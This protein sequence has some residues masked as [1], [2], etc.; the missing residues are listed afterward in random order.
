MAAKPGLPKPP[1]TGDDDNAPMSEPELDRHRK[2]APPRALTQYKG[3]MIV[4]NQGMLGYLMLPAKFELVD[5]KETS[6]YRLYEYGVT[7][8]EKMKIGHWIF[9]SKT[10][11][12]TEPAIVGLRTLLNTEPHRVSDEEM[13]FLEEV[14]PQELYGHSGAFDI[15]N[16]RTETFA[17]KTVLTME[18][19][20]WDDD[21]R[22]FGMFYFGDSSCTFLETLHFESSDFDYR[23]TFLSAKAAFLRIKWND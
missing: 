4:S 14:I 10:A 13:E 17:N 18:N 12:M 7:G 2:G 19:R 15:V 23:K 9:D 8:N 6:T 20:W 3:R 1:D 16:L 22:A 11:P 5:S 21:L